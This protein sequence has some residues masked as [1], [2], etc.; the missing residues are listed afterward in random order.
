MANAR[1]L[2]YQTALTKLQND[3]KIQT[4]KLNAQFKQDLETINTQ[5]ATMQKQF[6]DFKNNQNLILH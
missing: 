1:E 5:K 6:D 4:D 3:N 2:E